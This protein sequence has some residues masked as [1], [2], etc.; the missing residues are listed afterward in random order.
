MPAL[1]TPPTTAPNENEGRN[2]NWGFLKEALKQ[3]APPSGQQPQNPTTPAPAPTTQTPPPA[4]P[5]T[6]ANVAQPKPAGDSSG[7]HDPDEEIV[8]G[9][10][11]PKSDDFK[12]V[13]NAANEA[14]KKL[15]EIESAKKTIEEQYQ[16]AQKELEEAR[17]NPAVTAKELEEARA[18]AAKWK[19]QYSE[20]ALETLPEFTAKYQARFDE[21]TAGLKAMLGAKAEK[22]LAAL[23]LPD[24]EDK[25][26]I[27]EKLT[28]GLNEF[29]KGEIFGT[30][31]ELRKINTERNKELAQANEKLGKI[32]QERATKAQERQAALDREFQQTLSKMQDAKDG[33]PGFILREEKTPEDKQYNT[34][35]KERAQIAHKIYTGQLDAPEMAR[36]A[37]M[38]ANAPYLLEQLKASAAREE[39]MAAALKQLQGS[40]PNVQ[41]QGGGRQQNQ[42]QNKS[43]SQI[44]SEGGQDE[45]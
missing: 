41:N 3:D 37:A 39:Q 45:D 17:K 22:V 27:L 8:S 35:V 30:N 12:R 26:E 25:A 7:T 43:W 2:A 5:A 21:A 31:R 10:R 44:L 1:E 20:V 42:N 18:E 11:S 32:A 29:Q 9:K 36:Q 4:Q 16:K 19:S 33:I 38:A 23:Q 13:K 6:P 40:A 24:G 28:D 34:M 14:R 15:E